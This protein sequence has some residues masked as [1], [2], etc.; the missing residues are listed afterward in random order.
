MSGNLCKFA[1]LIELFVFYSITSNNMKKV[2]SFTIISAVMLIAGTTNVY[3]QNTVSIGGYTAS[4]SSVPI[5]CNWY[6][7]ISQFIYTADEIGEQC[8]IHS[9]SFYHGDHP[10]LGGG[11]VPVDRN[12]KVYF[13]LTLYDVDYSD[14]SWI[15]VN[16]ADLVANTVVTMPNGDAT[17][18]IPL[19]APYAYRYD[20]N[21][22]VTI[23]DNSTSAEQQH[24]FVGDY[25]SSTIRSLYSRRDNQ[26]FSIH[27]FPDNH[28][29]SSFRPRITFATTELFEVEIGR[30]I[31][32]WIDNY[33]CPINHAAIGDTVYFAAKGPDNATYSWEFEGGSSS[34]YSGLNAA[35]V[36]NS[37]GTYTVTLTAT[38]GNRTAT[39][40]HDITIL[41][42]T[43]VWGDT[44]NYSDGIVWDARGYQNRLAGIRVPKINLAGR[45]SLDEVDIY[46]QGTGSFVL[47]VYQGDTPTD[48]NIIFNNSYEVTTVDQWYSI[49]I[50]DGLSLDPDKDLWIGFGY[51]G[52]SDLSIGVSHNPVDRNGFC[53]WKRDNGLV[54]FA[55]YDGGWCYPLM[56]RA[57]TSGPGS[58]EAIDLADDI[59]VDLYPNPTTGIVRIE[60]A[61]PVQHLEVFS[62]TGSLLIDAGNA[63]S[64]DLGS[65][66]AGTYL[67]RITTAN[68]TAIRKIVKQ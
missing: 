1:A 13:T 58:P 28:L 65:L 37:A 34:S 9:I 41:D 63:S 12:I 45:Q 10:E 56:I 48:N 55:H 7:T 20:K 17:V 22:V 52:E 40:T 32:P 14:H 59:Q 44:I 30:G 68:G 42:W 5:D 54:T 57:I 21:L 36:W 33:Y 4:S 62:L 16:D 25:A 53:F 60:T 27:S 29:S 19:D 51:D 3:G 38:R 18:T 8:Y 31:L 15:P 35:A 23:V 61:E 47:F 39:A 49:H 66:A 64:I 11:C 24:Y 50:P 26:P 46:T 67:L 6:N 2:L 43:A